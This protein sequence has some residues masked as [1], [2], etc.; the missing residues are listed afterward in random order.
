MGGLACEAAL[1]ESP[2]SIKEG[3]HFPVGNGTGRNALIPMSSGKNIIAGAA[4]INFAT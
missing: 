3:F 2:V 1:S 4:R